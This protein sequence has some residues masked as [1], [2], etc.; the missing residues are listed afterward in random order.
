MHLSSPISPRKARSLRVGFWTLLII[1]IT[2]GYFVDRVNVN[3]LKEVS[4]TNAYE[5]VNLYRAKL[6]NQLNSNLQMVRGLAVAVAE[7]D[8]L[9]Q[10]RFEKIAAPLFEYSQ[11]L[12]NIGAAPN[13]VITWMYPLAG[14]E[15]AVGLDYTTVPAQRDAAL[16]AR[17]SKQIVMAGPLTLVQGGEALI[18]RVPVFDSDSDVFWGLLSVV[19]D[20]EKLYFVSEIP[21]LQDK[22]EIAIRKLTD[23]DNPDGGVFL[24]DARVLNQDAVKLSI[25]LTTD[26]QWELF[27]Y[28]KSGWQADAAHLWPFR[29]TL[30]TFISLFLG[31]FVFLNRIIRQIQDN[32]QHLSTMSHLAEVGAWSVNVKTREIIC[33][34]ATKAIV[35][36]EPSFQ[37]GWLN[38][39]E[40]FQSGHYRRRIQDLMDS[41]IKNQQPFEEEFIITTLKGRSR[42]IS[43]KA[44]PKVENGRTIEVVGSMQNIDS[45][46]KMELEHDK[47][48]RHNELLARITTH[49]AVLSNQIDLA[50]QLITDALCTGLSSARATIWQMSDDH[51]KL[52]PLAFSHTK[53]K[54]WEQFPPWKAGSLPMLFETIERQKL[55]EMPKARRNELTEGLLDHYLI[56]FEIQAML[57]CPI[58]HHG[59]TIGV[60]IAEYEDA[61][62]YWSANDKRFIQALSVVL[63]SL[64]ANKES[65]KARQLAQVE[66][67]LAQQSAK[68]KS[69]FLA[70]MSHEIRTPMN[71]ILGMLTVLQQSQ[72]SS[73]QQHQIH[74][75]QSSAESLLT[76]INDILDFSKIEAGKIDIEKVDVNLVELL[77]ETIEAFAIKADE[78]ATS[79]EIDCRNL[80]IGAAKTDPH[81]LRQILNNLL[82]NAIKFTEQGRVTLTAYTEQNGQETRLWCSIE[83]TGIGIAK[84]KLATIFDSFTQADSS[85]T[86][87]YGGTGLGLSIASQLC[88]LLGGQLSAYSKL[89]VGSTF[90]FFVTLD[91]PYAI[92]Q[93]DDS[94]PLLTILIPSDVDT[95]SLRHVLAPWHITSHVFH[96]VTP[97]LAFITQH[98]NQA[99]MLVADPMALN[100]QEH[101][102]RLKNALADSSVR[103]AKLSTPAHSNTT[104]WAGADPMLETLYPLTPANALVMYQDAKSVAPEATAVLKGHVLLVEDNKV[105]QIVASNL[106]SKM[107]LTFSIANHGLEALDKLKSDEHFD[108]ILMDC[109]MPELDGYETS[110]QIRQGNAGQQRRSIAIIA[111]TANAMVGDKEKCLA[112]GM[113][114]YLSKPLQYKE[115][116]DTIKLWL[117]KSTPATH[118]KTCS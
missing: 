15:K 60:L 79:L 32:E 11:I 38:S 7:K 85:T 84:E 16:L 63:G 67:E 74:L 69:E 51:Q 75:A 47:M 12:R 90:T 40:F 96:E 78:K 100:E 25:N 114:A 14:N 111:L 107:G 83:D 24:G 103:I 94:A 92:E 23:V 34:D 86:R 106:L 37:P 39:I 49:E 59:V 93:L 62:L 76:I 36:G 27:A 99:L 3:R 1:V 71:G 115:L 19:I 57:F 70:S 95:T 65:Q 33:S 17:D 26:Q 77:S 101:V 82:S 72:L 97:L 4:R 80:Q 68:I 110:K 54:A 98:K 104:L 109:Q 53:S 28:P 44:Y 73:S 87:K 81:R 43:I 20:L 113:D 10:A 108:L 2:T 31:A 116:V 52:S 41:V 30:I 8:N 105:N 64:Y 118:S 42:W 22:Y 13:L 5:E 50:H 18:A 6:E 46:K 55:I 91:E 21:Q 88:V 61:S 56:P 112:A 102:N 89:G 58:V 9:D 117:A 45:R 48:A 29:L 35:D 66:K